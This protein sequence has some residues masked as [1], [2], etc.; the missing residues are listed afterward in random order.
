MTIVA[1]YLHYTTLLNFSCSTFY[2]ISYV[3]SYILLQITNS[4]YISI[5]QSSTFVSSPSNIFL[6]SIIVHIISF[7][8]DMMNGFTEIML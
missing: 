4:S 2:S 1:L 7:F 3:S 8:M 6:T 5:Y